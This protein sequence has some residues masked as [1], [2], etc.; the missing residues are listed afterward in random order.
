MTVAPGAR[1]RPARW[2]LRL[3]A[4]LAARSRRWL[5]W[6][7]PPRGARRVSSTMI[8]ID[9]TTAELTAASAVEPGDWLSAAPADMT[10]RAVFRLVTSVTANDDGTRTITIGRSHPRHLAV[11][12]DDDPPLWR[13]RGDPPDPMT[14]RPLGYGRYTGAPNVVGCPRARTDMTP[15]VARDGR[16]AC[17]NDGVC[18]GCGEHPAH[19]LRLLVRHVTEPPRETR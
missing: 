15:C 17:A 11:T 13:Y 14:T 18:V 19:L 16:S 7:P 3:G 6:T 5:A 8:V 4:W 2:R 1:R 10:G 12:T 9:I